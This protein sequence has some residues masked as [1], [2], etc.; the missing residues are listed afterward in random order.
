MNKKQ[1]LISLVFV[2]IFSF[3]GGIVG[4][5]FSSGT[6]IFAKDTS[7]YTNP[8]KINYLKSDHI[9]VSEI[10][11]ELITLV[12]DKDQTI[13]RLSYNQFGSPVFMLY[14]SAKPYEIKFPE[15]KDTSKFTTKDWAEWRS[16]GKTTLPAFYLGI[17]DTEPWMVF[18]DKD[19]DERIS[20][21]VANLEPIISLQYNNMVRL[22]LGTNPLRQKTTGN[23]QKIKGSICAFD[24]KSNL[25]GRLPV[26]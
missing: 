8:H 22:Q 2:S 15:V 10:Q 11:A 19:L 20:L 25:I 5:T 21:G 3:L 1:F 14:S 12:N 13:G 16:K 7:T 23:E 24:N 26:E 9:N 6:N 18:S 17:F 4:G